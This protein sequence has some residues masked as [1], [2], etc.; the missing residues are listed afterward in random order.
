MLAGVATSIASGL[1]SAGVENYLLW[2]PLVG[3]FFLACFYAAISSI[4]KEV[5][6][7]GKELGRWETYEDL[8]EAE[9]EKV[10]ADPRRLETPMI[11]ELPQPKVIFEKARRLRD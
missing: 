3:L 1:A 6:R 8:A 7:E 2:V 4:G 11:P 9:V 10:W 5:M